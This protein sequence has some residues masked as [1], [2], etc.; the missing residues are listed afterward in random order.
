VKEIIDITLTLGPELP[1]WPDSGELQLIPSSR[2][3]GGDDYNVSKLCFDLHMGTHVDA[4]WHCIDDGHTVDEL[5]LDVL[6]GPAFVAHVPDVRLITERDLAG[7]DLS[8]DTTRL[9]LRTDNSELWRAGVKEFRKDYVALSHDAAEWIVQRGIR[10]L[11]VDYLSVE[12]FDTGPRAHRVLLGANVVL[13][14]GLNLAHVQPGPYEFTCLPMKVKGADGAPARAVLL[15]SH[16]D[17]VG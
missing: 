3:S 11:G 16:G 13:L 5:P 4:P 7:L 15:A 14:E 8:A 17:K 12:P 9:L 10:L 6:I 2:I 1:R